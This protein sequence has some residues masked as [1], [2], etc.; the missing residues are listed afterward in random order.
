MLDSARIYLFQASDLHRKTNN[1]AGLSNTLMS[2][3]EY[4]YLL[5]DFENALFHLNLTIEHAQNMNSKR[6]LKEAFLL[7]S[8]I[9]AQQDN[10]KE[11]YLN[12]QKF[13]EIHSSMYDVEKINQA[14]ALEQRL[15]QQEKENDLVE[16]E[17]QK[18]KTINWLLLS[19][20]SLAV[21]IGVVILIY[22]FRLRKLSKDLKGSKEKAEESD[23][24][25]SRFLQT[26]SHEIRTPLNGIIG[27]SEMIRSK[28]LKDHEMD[29]I[30][31]MI[32]KNSEDLIST[33]ENLVDIAHLST[34][35]FF[36]KRTKFALN[37]LLES[38]INQAKENVIYRN[39]ADLKILLDTK[40]DIE[41]NTDKN[42]IQKIILHLIKN[43]LQYTE[44]GSIQ[45]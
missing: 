41:I 25:K 11:A 14:K 28:N 4:Y 24:L 2:V 7:K 34:N 43:A 23:K 45:V 44:K 32:N 15:L 38:I 12:F 27:F 1:L 8:K 40:E 37:P 13:F 20:V 36:V 17:L 29:Q 6:I 19:S 21:L 9:D 42:F 26:I 39:K 31:E 18:Q 30:N 16:L 33:I 22:L 35:Q 5:N 3:S 10:F